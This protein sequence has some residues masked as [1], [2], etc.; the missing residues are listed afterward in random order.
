MRLKYTIL[1]AVSPFLQS[2]VVGKATNP[3]RWGILFSV[4]SQKFDN[5]ISLLSPLNWDT[6]CLTFI[7][8]HGFFFLLFSV[9]RK[10]SARATDR[11]VSFPL[12]HWKAQFL[13][14]CAVRIGCQPVVRWTLLLDV[15]LL[16]RCHLSSNTSSLLRCFDDTAC[17]QIAGATEPFDN[18]LLRYIMR[19]SYSEGVLLQGCFH[20][21]Q[22]GW[23]RDGCRKMLRQIK[24]DLQKD[25]R[26]TEACRCGVWVAEVR[27][28]TL[29]FRGSFHTTLSYPSGSPSNNYLCSFS[30]YSVAARA[31]FMEKYSCFVLIIRWLLRCGQKQA[32]KQRAFELWRRGAWQRRAALWHGTWWYRITLYVTAHRPHGRQLAPQE[33]TLCNTRDNQHGAGITD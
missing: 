9:A 28:V 23:S 1:L 19:D 30:F 25:P 16:Y 4:A 22:Y 27:A 13:L 20:L 21:N 26:I 29:S 15:L 33:S 17:L 12:G 8:V 32:W 6:L 2:P 18:V 10:S 7:F 11:A 14:C 24:C 31:L 3:G 5:S